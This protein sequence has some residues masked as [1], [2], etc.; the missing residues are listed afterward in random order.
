MI[1]EILI[2]PDPRLAEIAESTEPGDV[3][4]ALLVDMIDT[5]AANNGLGLAATQIGEMKRAVVVHDPKAGTVYAILNPVISKKSGI[6]IKVWEG[7]LSYPGKTFLK[8]R[9]FSCQ[10]DGISGNG[11]PMKIQAKGDLACVFQHEV[12]HLNGISGA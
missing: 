10:V 12:D 5:M 11:N 4:T 6:K 7:C 8:R 2:A 9:S 1:R 3:S